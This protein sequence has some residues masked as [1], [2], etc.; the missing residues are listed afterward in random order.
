M[1]PYIRPE[2]K[3]FSGERTRRILEAFEGKRHI[4]QFGADRASRLMLRPSVPSIGWALRKAVSFVFHLCSSSVLPIAQVYR[5][6]SGTVINA[7][8]LKCQCEWSSIKLIIELHLSCTNTASLKPLRGAKV[9]TVASGLFVAD[10][11]WRR[12]STS[13]YGSKSWPE[14]NE[15]S[16]RVSSRR[17]RTII[18][19]ISWAPRS[20]DR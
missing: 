19:N 9:L 4:Y 1:S 11:S 20:M 17:A 6:H 5:L 10:G 18:V 14:A 8:E 13:S 7:L 15:P 16:P 12:A 3:L 2:E